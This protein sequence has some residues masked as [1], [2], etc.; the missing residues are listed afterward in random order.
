LRG[1]FLES[2]GLRLPIIGLLLIQLNAPCGFA[3]EA[4]VHYGLTYWLARKAGFDK[5]NA[6]IVASGDYGADKGKYNPA[7]WAVGLHIILDGDVGAAN[8]V[9]DLHFA[10]YQTL[11][12]APAQRIVKPGSPAAKRAAIKSTDPP[13]AGE[14]SAFAL[15]KLGLSLHP[16]QDS[17]AHQ[18]IPDIPFRPGRQV[19][20]ELSFGHPADRGGWYS[21]N[22]DITCLD[23]HPKEVVAAAKA[24]YEFMLKF[25]ASH[26]AER[27]QKSADWTTLEPRVLA[28]AKACTK[29]E[30]LRWFRSDESVPFSDYTDQGFVTTISTPGLISKFEEI[31]TPDHK[32]QKQYKGLQVQAAALTRELS[33]TIHRFLDSWLVKQD[34][35]AALQF[36]NLNAIKSQLFNAG[37]NAPVIK[38]VRG[39][40]AMPFSGDEKSDDAAVRAWAERFL[41]LWLVEDHGLVNQPGHG[42]PWEKEYGQL[43][44]E[45][46]KIPDRFRLVS[47]KSLEDAIYAPEGSAR[48]EAPYFVGDVLDP[49][50]GHTA[51]VAFQF[52]RLPYDTLLVFFSEGPQGWKIERMY[53]IVI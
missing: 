42:M 31:I 30:K 35:P 34:I 53:W 28:F 36:I 21:H 19:H 20:P 6:E 9:R 15:E 29:E 5:K 4:D 51:V 2:R 37:D 1:S 8:G 32:E 16:L 13:S 27:G 23:D 33:D 18:G 10:S 38:P 40:R 52:K 48:Q 11:P 17:W 43:P 45:T 7:P 3:S 46:R 14:P 25:L 41:V 39:R 12:A 26:P 22:A 47:Y 44:S 24:S 49:P 50:P